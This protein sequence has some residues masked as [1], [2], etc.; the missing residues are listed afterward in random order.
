MKV[1]IISDTHN[2]HTNFGALPDGDMI[3][4]AGDVTTW[5]K[6]NEL[7]N[8]A[9]WWKELPYEHKIVI[10]GNHDQCL[11]KQPELTNE[12]FEGTHYLLDSS[13]T[14]EGI[15]FY[16]S[17]WTPAFRDFFFMKERG[18]DIAER[19]NIIPED[20]DVLITHGPPMGYGD[21]TM[22]GVRTGCEDLYRRLLELNLQYHICGHIHENYGIRRLE[23][24]VLIN[25]S[26]HVGLWRHSLERT[27]PV[28]VE[29]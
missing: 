6:E 18:K 23:D 20:T 11:Q 8:F 2:L 3:I 13:V 14:I 1:V 27:P 16:G 25:A 21:L 26:N 5:G 15:K 12:V 17:P 9:R 28:V 4:H 7:R 29:M 19:W 10:A 24:T 22:P